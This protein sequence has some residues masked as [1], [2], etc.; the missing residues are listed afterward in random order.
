MSKRGPGLLSFVVGAAAGATALFLSKP[1]NRVKAEKVAKK[2][3]A[4]AKRMG[5]EYQKNPEAFKKKVMT[6]ATKVAKKV[7]KTAKTSQV[8][9]KTKARQTAKSKSKK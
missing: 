3:A 7:A 9:V 2:V 5:A 8:M 4:K 1:E 6:Q